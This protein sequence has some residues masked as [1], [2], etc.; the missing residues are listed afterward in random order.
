[1]KKLCHKTLLS[2]ALAGAVTVAACGVCGMHAPVQD[3]DVP[4]MVTTAVREETVKPM[5]I[6]TK[7]DTPEVV[8]YKVGSDSNG[9]ALYRYYTPYNCFVVYDIK[10]VDVE[11]RNI[12]LGS[13]NAAYNTISFHNLGY[14]EVAHYVSYAKSG[15]TC[16]P[17]YYIV[18]ASCPDCGVRSEV[19]SVIY[20]HYSEAFW[21]QCN[22][23][24]TDY[25]IS[26]AI[27]TKYDDL[28]ATWKHN[29]SKDAR[30]YFSLA[31]KGEV[32][33]EG[34]GGKDACIA[35]PTG[36]WF[37]QN[38]SKTKTVTLGGVTFT[39]RVTPSEVSVKASEEVKCNSYDTMFAFYT[40]DV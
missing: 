29:G 38:P 17:T 2:L 7:V 25:M 28:G 24:C 33:D 10:N 27:T 26:D 11:H 16:Y 9:N 23:G 32:F 36:N 31:Y 40:D 39:I 3:G 6:C 8:K 15:K 4:L 22:Q 21:S 37:N 20:E 30:I 1:M 19:N 5:G 13:N 12:D 34:D 18:S 35:V 14:N